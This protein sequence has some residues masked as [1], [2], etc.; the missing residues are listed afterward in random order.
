MIGIIFSYYNVYWID[1][2]IGIIIS[3][4]IIYTGSKV[5]I[6]SYE[7]LMDQSIDNESKLKIEEVI[8]NFSNNIKMGKMSSIPIGYKYIIVLTIYVDGMMP[9]Y[10][11]HNITK[12]L[13]R[14]IKRKVKKIDRVIIHV[15]PN[16]N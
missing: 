7:V 15:N 9:T 6:E 8:Y 10:E 16:K 5:V 2:I 3:F 14:Q 1:S 12:E 13:Q 4:W 11:A